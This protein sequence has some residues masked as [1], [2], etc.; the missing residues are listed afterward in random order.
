M[1]LRDKIKTR[2][3]R[4]APGDLKII[5]DLIESLSAR[6]RLRKAIKQKSKEHYIEA[7]NLLGGKG[8]SSHDII[9]GRE[10]RI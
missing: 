2:I 6:K 10:E 5:N 8:L 4:L 1:E 7:I 9:T 3:D